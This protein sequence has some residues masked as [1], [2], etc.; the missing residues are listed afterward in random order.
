M[1]DCTLGSSMSNGAR[2]GI[3]AINMARPAALFSCQHCAKS[4]GKERFPQG[5]VVALLDAE[6]FGNLFD[7]MTNVEVVHDADYAATTGA[8]DKHEL[9]V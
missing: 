6:L 4:W 9:E 7:V 8:L 5:F 1:N 2:Y 3:T